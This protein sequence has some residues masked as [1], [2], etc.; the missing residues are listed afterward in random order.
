MSLVSPDLWC[1]QTLPS[2]LLLLNRKETNF[3]L[4]FFSICCAATTATTATSAQRS[5]STTHS[6]QIQGPFTA[7]LIAC[8]APAGLIQLR[9]CTHVDVDGVV[10]GNEWMG[11]K[12]ETTTSAVTTTTVWAWWTEEVSSSSLSSLSFPP[13]FFNFLVGNVG[14]IWLHGVM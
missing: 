11:K 9:H 12:G 2:P 10:H 7:A 1:G 14:N 13:F 3:S 5:G 8:F 4:F 6:E